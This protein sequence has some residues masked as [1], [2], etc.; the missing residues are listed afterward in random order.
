MIL[1]EGP[2]CVGKT[3]VA[4]ALRRLLPGWSYRHF[5]V[6]PS[7]VRPYY[8]HAWPITD[9]HPRVIIDRLHWSEYAYGI[10]TR[11]NFDY[12]EDEWRNVELLLLSRATTVVYM[13]DDSEAIKA[14]W[15]QSQKRQHFNVAV[16]DGVI[17]RYGNLFMKHSDPLSHLNVLAFTLPQLID[18]R[19]N[20]PTDA[21]RDLARDAEDAAG[22]CALPASVGCGSLDPDFVILGESPRDQQSVGGDAPQVPLSAGPA[23]EWLWRALKELNAP[24]WDGY[25]TNA[26]AFRSEVELGAYLNSLN[27]RVVVALGAR[28]H[29][30]VFTAQ[31]TRALAPHVEVKAVDHPAY[32]RRFKHGQYETWRNE[33]RY[34]IDLPYW[35]STQRADGA[36]HADESSPL[37]QIQ[38]DALREG[39]FISGGSES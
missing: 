23:C 18:P 1:L 33:L 32:V 19:T 36:T 30:A 28:A 34:A 29:G 15:A 22:A 2:E 35:Q 14:R 10:P 9:A 26:S 20:R 16:A 24:W 8:Y 31:S 6:P 12:T 21:L 17:A 11:G 37:T 27:P 39:R 13:T 25:Y 38:W 4:M 3:T 5:S 7:C